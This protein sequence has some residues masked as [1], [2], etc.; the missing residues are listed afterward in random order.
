[1]GLRKGAR[2]NG[3]GNGNGSGSESYWFLTHFVV[4]C[5]VIIAI[6]RY[7]ARCLRGDG[8]AY[9]RGISHD[10]DAFE[11]GVVPGHSCLLYE[12]NDEL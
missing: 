2:G 10:P 11:T 3:N 9:R 6:S 8:F 7:E 4:F 12:Y 1:M 5:C